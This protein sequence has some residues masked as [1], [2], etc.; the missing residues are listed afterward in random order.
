MKRS[1]KIK[2]EGPGRNSLVVKLPGVIHLRDQG[3]MQVA[4]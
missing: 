1:R 2:G 4:K 3:W